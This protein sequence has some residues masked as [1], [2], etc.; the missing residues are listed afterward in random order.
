MKVD[1]QKRKRGKRAWDTERGKIK[2][3]YTGSDVLSA[4]DS[5]RFPCIFPIY[6]QLFSTF[7][8]FSSEFIFEVR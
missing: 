8:Y 4:L 2:E 7:N 6:F 1:I 3:L 5:V